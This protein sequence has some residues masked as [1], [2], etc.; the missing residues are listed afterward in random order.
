MDTYQ[1][2]TPIANQTAGLSR[3]GAMPPKRRM[4]PPPMPKPKTY[5]DYLDP[6][7][8]PKPPAPRFSDYL[9]KDGRPNLEVIGNGVQTQFD[10]ANQANEDRYNQSLGLARQSREESL[11]YLDKYGTDAKDQIDRNLKRT[12]G[13]IDQSAIDRGIY[14][15]S[16]VD[17]QKRLE[18]ESAGRLSAAVDERAN[19]HRAD[20]SSRGY[21]EELGIIGSRVDQG[22][23]VD[24][25]MNMIQ[26]EAALRAEESK[27]NQDASQQLAQRNTSNAAQPTQIVNGVP[28]Y[29]NQPYMPPLASG[30]MGN[31]GFQRI[32]GAS[33]GAP[34]MGEN[35]TITNGVR[36]DGL[37]VGAAPYNGYLPQPQSPQQQQKSPAKPAV[38]PGPSAYSQ[39]TLRYATK[40]YARA[41]GGSN[42]PR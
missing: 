34:G 13:G 17:D 37:S 6:R 27:R 39:Q 12:V 22:P 11:G 4:A 25:Y 31:Q 3:P 26:R 32:P 18:R 5:S 19:L 2:R 8:K 35:Y 42:R 29:G 40:R 28:V 23:N 36:T 1:T 21:S 33:Y 9:D 14:N 10:N 16:T 7:G 15:I 20:V 24:S 38:N 41:T 30:A